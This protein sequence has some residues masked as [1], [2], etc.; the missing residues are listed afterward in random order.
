MHLTQSQVKNLDG[1]PE[2][3]VDTLETL[4]ILGRRPLFEGGVRTRNLTVG[5][6]DDRETS[7]AGNRDLGPFLKKR[8]DV[9]PHE[10]FGGKTS[11]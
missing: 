3:Q 5:K 9:T 8:A 10:T 1:E 4:V 7:C 11:H 6:N 2:S